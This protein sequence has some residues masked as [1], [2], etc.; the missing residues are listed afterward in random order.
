MELFY[1][2]IFLCIQIISSQRHDGLKNL[3]VLFR[4]LK[5]EEKEKRYTEQYCKEIAR[6]IFEEL[7]T[8]TTLEEVRH[9][10]ITVMF[11]VVTLYLE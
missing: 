2:G 5:K 10:L 3:Q 11:L 8:L 1:F 7:H 4:A 9:V 6:Q